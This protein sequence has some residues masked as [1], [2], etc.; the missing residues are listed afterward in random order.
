MVLCPRVSA[1]DKPFDLYYHV[2]RLATYRFAT[3]SAGLDVG[4]AINRFSELRAGYE[5]GHL[6][7]G[8]EIGQ[9]ILP[10]P[11]GRFGS[12]SIRYDLDT[13][14][15]ALVPRRGEML[16]WQVRWFDAMF[17][18]TNGFP[19]AELSF[20]AF[21]P[22]SNP[23][24][25]YLQTY[26]GTTFGHQ[27]TGLPQ[28]FLGGPGRLGAYGLNEIRGNQ[29]FLGRLGYLHEIFQLPPLIGNKIYFTSAFELG[30]MWGNRVDSRLPMD[31]AVGFVM[32]TMLGPIGVGGSVGDRG[33]QKWYFQ[34]GR[35]F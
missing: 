30:K 7:S 35:V 2:N 23:A 10:T 8:V 29:Y 22:V 6:G 17:G 18:A 4:Y 25:I 24:S 13:R 11:S 14:D 1:V 21:K 3:Y 28:F 33:H 26:V 19:L 12:T 5:A 34:V 9:S 27:A 31:G 32:D 20:S 15:K 16:G